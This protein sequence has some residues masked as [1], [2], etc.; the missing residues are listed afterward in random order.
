MQSLLDLDRL[1]RVRGEQRH[2]VG[3]GGPRR[4][5]GESTGVPPQVVTVLDHEVAESLPVQA[6]VGQ[7]GQERMAQDLRV[8]GGAV[9]PE[10]F[11]EP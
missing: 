3:V 1:R 9:T 4:H 11:A 6:A 2:G 5:Q 8:R 7:A 10:L